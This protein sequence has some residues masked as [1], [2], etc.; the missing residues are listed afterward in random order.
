MGGLLDGG[1]LVGGDLLGWGCLRVCLVAEVI[2][3]KN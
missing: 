2:V 1:L 3:G